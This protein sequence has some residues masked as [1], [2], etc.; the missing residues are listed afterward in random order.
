MA[1]SGYGEMIAQLVGR[2]S[3]WIRHTVSVLCG[4]ESGT[5]WLRLLGCGSDNP[6]SSL[7]AV[8]F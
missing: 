6:D 1:A 2:I 5:F 4:R 8:C 7:P 3:S